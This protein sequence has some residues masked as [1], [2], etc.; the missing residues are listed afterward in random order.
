MI[1]LDPSQLA[2]VEL[3]THARLGVI[4]G[5]PG[6]GKTT[7]LRAALDA[8]DARGESYELAAPTGKAAI[9]M[10]EATGRDAQTIHRLLAYGPDERGV[11][12]FRRNEFSPV[13]ASAVIIDESSMIDVLLADALLRAINPRTT[14]L[15]LV[16]DANQLPPVGAGQVFADLIASGTVPVARLTTVHRAAAES[17]VCTN[18]PII[19]AG[20]RPALERRDDFAWVGAAELPAAEVPARVI[21]A[22]GDLQRTRGAELE[23]VQVLVPQNKGGAGAFALCESLRAAF[24]PAHDDD[25]RE[26]PAAPDVL[27]R[28]R[29]RVIQTRNDYELGVFNGEIG[30]VVAVEHGLANAH[31]TVRFAGDAGDAD[32]LVEYDWSAARALRL[33][34]ALTIH[35]SQGSQWPWVVVVCH[36]THSQ[37]L[38]RR[39]LYTAIT[40]ASRGVVIVGD[41]MGLVRA[42][43]SNDDARRN[44]WLAQRLRGAA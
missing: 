34:Y 7:C 29:D 4:T 17:W 37:M 43:R 5:G 13:Q 3:A 10:R 27:L 38:T 14:R 35:K 19:L 9:R 8:L 39:L 44:T 25:P 20:G 16:G 30:E 24:N 40:R 15:I 1:A 26:W 41:K 33:A 36:T 42:V 18:A 21:S 2:A 6:C 11:L 28:L 23:D 32:R 22:V 31:V 12:G